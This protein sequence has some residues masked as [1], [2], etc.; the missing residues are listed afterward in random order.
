MLETIRTMQPDPKT[1]IVNFVSD[2]RSLA[3]IRYH[4]SQQPRF[5]RGFIQDNFPMLFAMICL[6]VF[7]GVLSIC[8]CFSMQ[9]STPRRRFWFSLAPA[10]LGLVGVWE[11][12]PISMECGAF[13]LHFDFGWLFLIPLLLGGAGFISYLR[14]RHQH[15]A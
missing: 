1:L 4:H 3:V 11:R 15:V 6:V 2:P 5:M 8:A 13:H 9:A 12:I 14:V 7:V 10:L